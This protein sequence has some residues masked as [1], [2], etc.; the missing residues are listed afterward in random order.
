MWASTCGV[1]RTMAIGHSATDAATERGKETW[2]TYP[3]TDATITRHFVIR[4]PTDRVIRGPPEAATGQKDPQGAAT[5]QLHDVEK[6]TAQG[7][8]SG[9]EIGRKDAPRSTFAST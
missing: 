1:G 7:N 6:S 9:P 3:T 8:D 4:R 5:P 2:R